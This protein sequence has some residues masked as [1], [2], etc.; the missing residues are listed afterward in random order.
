MRLREKKKMDGIRLRE[1]RK[2]RL[3]EEQDFV[4]LM[5]GEDER[6]IEKE[7]AFLIFKSGFVFLVFLFKINLDLKK[8]L[9]S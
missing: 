7:N 4:G 1:R 8:K 2:G 9:R 5:K 6:E 3:R